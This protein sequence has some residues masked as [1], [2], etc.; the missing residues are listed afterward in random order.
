MKK[1]IVLFVTWF[2]LLNLINKLSSQVFLDNTSY[3]LPKNIKLSHRYWIVPWLN[4][5]GRN[6]LEVVVNGYQSKAQ[7]NDLRVFFPFFPLLITILS[8]NKIIN[9]IIVGLTISLTSF[10]LSL[11]IFNKLM[12][13]DRISKDKRLKTVILLLLFPASFYF[14]A[15]YTESL[16]LFLTLLVFYFLNNKK[17]LLASIYTA[18]ATATRLVGLTLIPIVFWEAYRTYRKTKK[19]PLSIII[20]PFGF[21]FYSFYMQITTGNAFSVVTQHKEWSRNINIFGVFIALKEGL[22]KV[23]FKSSLSQNNLIIYSIETIEFIFAIFLILILLFS[24]KKIKFSYWLYLLLSSIF[25][26]S[27]NVLISIPRLI[28]PMFPIFIY[29]SQVIS[30]KTFY[31]ISFIFLVLLVYLSSL[32]L[33]GYWVA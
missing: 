15:Y 14:A 6:Y 11:F 19:F 13:Q 4:F 20:T 28:I 22:Q 29:L 25:I 23:I 17:F 8:L 32:F 3:E 27:S 2:L 9:P 30:K 1:I 10:L 5:D 26:F 16:F 31:F 12:I 21:I 7:K 33:R 18:I 24:F